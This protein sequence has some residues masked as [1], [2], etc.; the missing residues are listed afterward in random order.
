[1]AVKLNNSDEY[2]ALNRDMFCGLDTI[3]L[4]KELTQKLF[5]QRLKSYWKKMYAEL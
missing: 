1:M 4:S 3:K 5:K 2:E